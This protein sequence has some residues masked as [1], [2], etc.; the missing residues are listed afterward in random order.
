MTAHQP[1]LIWIQKANGEPETFELAG[2][3]GT[4]RVV[5]GEPGRQSGVWRIWSNPNKSD[6]YVGI[7][8]LLGYQKWSLHES[9]DWRHQW[10]NRSIAAEWGNEGKR[11]IDQWSQPAEMAD[12]GWTKGFSIHVRHQD[13]VEVA[14]PPSVPPDTLW[15]PPP[16]EGHY[17]SLHVAI[18][19]PTQRRA[20][21][22]GFVPLDGF[23]LTDRRVVL[24][25]AAQEPVTDETNKMIAGALERA[26]KAAKAS[27]VDMS[28]VDAARAAVKCTSPEGDRYVWDVALP[29]P[30]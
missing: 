1:I 17:I 6:V 26:V 27:G 19:R 5:V 13:L 4:I 10:V 3:G 14:D 24:L 22:R 20:N 7:R 12:S 11:V 28:S 8:A 21:L 29:N 16:A 23:Y 9:G 2:P 15:V 18:A 30:L 25:G